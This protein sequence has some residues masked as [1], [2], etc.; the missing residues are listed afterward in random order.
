[1]EKRRPQRQGKRQ[2]DFKENWNGPLDL[3]SYAKFKVQTTAF[4]I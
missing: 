2:G 1:M 4:K 3:L